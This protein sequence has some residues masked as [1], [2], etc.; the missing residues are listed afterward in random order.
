MN[1]LFIAAAGAGKTTFIINEAIRKKNAK[2]LITTFTEAN[3]AEIRRKLI[4]KLG[5]IP[6][7]I[8]IQTW[9]TFLLEHGVRPY[10]SFLHEERAAGLLLV[11]A[12][13]GVKYTINGVPVFYRETEVKN[14][15]FDKKLDIYSDKISKFVFSVNK[16]SKGLVISR[17]AKI[18]D[19]IYID[20]VQDLLGY[21]LEIIKLLGKSKIEIILAGD[22]R[23]V[24][25]HTHWERKN[26]KY[27]DGKIL[28]YVNEKCPKLFLIDTETLKNTHRNNENICNF[29]NLLFPDYPR[30]SSIS[31]HE[32]TDHEGI[33]FVTRK[34][35]N[36]YL[37]RYKPIQLR[38]SKASPVNNALSPIYNFGEAK[39]L[40]FNR[41]IIYPT[42]PMLDW[43]KDP[44]SNLSF[45][46]RC[47]TYVAITRAIHSVAFVID[48]D[49]KDIIGSELMLFPPDDRP[50]IWHP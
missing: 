47:R 30:T 26:K 25:Y 10:Q 12:Q 35:V 48:D 24:T 1:K 33:F 28:D 27:R 32:E 13:S 31:T 19:A 39:G 42:A 5:Y 40:T 23:Q 29:A 14:H 15:Y 50:I 17:L 45:T 18:F 7:H 37:K 38:N 41:V 2:I 21:D 20:E 49:D 9:F 3:E 22:P 36:E 34:N 8:T 11:N 43:I 44:K 46:S 6:S 4:Q 16:I